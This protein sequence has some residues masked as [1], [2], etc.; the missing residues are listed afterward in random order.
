ME[1]AQITVT[2]RTAAPVVQPPSMRTYTASTILGAAI[3]VAQVEYR[4]VDGR[5][6]DHVLL[7]FPDPN[8]TLGGYI[9]LSARG[10]ITERFPAFLEPDLGLWLAGFLDTVRQMEAA[11]REQERAAQ[12]AGT[13]PLAAPE[14]RMTLDPQKETNNG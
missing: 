7:Q 11:R 5:F 1:N 8:R 14:L 4:V 13:E 3:C 9:V 6:D 12:Q 10:A 2:E